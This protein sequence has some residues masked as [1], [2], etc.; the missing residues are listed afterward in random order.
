MNDVKVILQAIAIEAQKLGSEVEK[1]MHPAASENEIEKSINELPF[2]LPPNIVDLYRWRDGVRLNEQDCEFRM[3][4]KF[5]FRP[6]NIAVETTL[7]LVGAAAD[8]ELQWRDSWYGLATDLM[9]DYFAVETARGE[10]YGRIFSVQQT[11]DPFPAF[12]SFITMLQSI[13]ECYKAGAYFIDD[14][15]LLDER[16][17]L[18]DSIYRALNQ[19]LSPL[20][21]ESRENLEESMKIA[22]RKFENEGRPDLIAKLRELADR[23]GLNFDN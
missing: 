18:S 22:K 13:L 3:F 11:H 4:P 17:E 16:R 6:I 8:P 12:W 5:M 14:S 1:Y 15:G 7:T 23:S 21:F 19:G 9:G 2:D 10:N 20:R